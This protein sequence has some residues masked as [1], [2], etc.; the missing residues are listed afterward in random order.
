MWYHHNAFTLPGATHR[1][2]VAQTALSLAR[3][4]DNSLAASSQPPAAKVLATLLDKLRS[5]SAPGRRGGLAL[6]RTMTKKSGG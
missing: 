6:A 2:G 3:V 1:P 5:V 4:L